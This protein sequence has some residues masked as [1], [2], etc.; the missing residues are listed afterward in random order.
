M[1]RSGI[2]RLGE[3]GLTGHWFRRGGE[4]SERGRG[5]RRGKRSGDGREKDGL[6]AGGVG[7]V[8]VEDGGGGL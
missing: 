7:R 4:K 1:K 5:E 6:E 8:G 2:F 3:L